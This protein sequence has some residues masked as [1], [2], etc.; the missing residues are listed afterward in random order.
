MRPISSIRD[1]ELW[2]GDENTEEEEEEE[3]RI[4][5]CLSLGQSANA[6][7]VWDTLSPIT[8]TRCFV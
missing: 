6:S 7:K 8:I 5:H 2:N 4:L 3:R 1:S